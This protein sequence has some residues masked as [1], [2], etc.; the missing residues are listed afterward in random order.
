MA[1]TRLRVKVR[2]G[3]N[4][5]EGEEEVEEEE[6]VVVEEGTE[7]EERDRGAGKEREEVG[8]CYYRAPP[9]RTAQYGAI[10][11][12]HPPKSRIYARASARFS[13][14]AEGWTRC[15]GCRLRRRRR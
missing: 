3:G 12:F 10:S 5:K 8:L 1:N 15:R 9:W 2:T 7:E 14:P 4:T 11:D 6:V 13:W